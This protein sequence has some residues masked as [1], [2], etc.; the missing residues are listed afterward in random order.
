MKVK[1]KQ[2]CLE[3]GN[4]P[5]FKRPAFADS[6]RFPTDVTQLTGQNIGELMGKYAALLAFVEQESTS[7]TILELRTEQELE[8]QQTQ[9]MLVNPRTVFLERWRLDIRMKQ[10]LKIQ[11]LRVRLSKIRE[12]KE[13]AASMVRT[14][15]RLINVLSRE[16]SRRLATQDGSRY[17]AH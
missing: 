10:D 16:L 11:S 17:A 2:Q 7:W 5:K 8:Q 3:I 4:L 1:S 12:L 13:R 15:D 6:L 9:F 14:Y